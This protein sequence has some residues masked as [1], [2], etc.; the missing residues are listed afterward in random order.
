M[1]CKAHHAAKAIFPARRTIGTKISHGTG[2]VLLRE[3]QGERHTVTVV[4]NGYVWRE[5]TY[6]SL[7]IIARIN[8]CLVQSFYAMVVRLS[9]ARG[10]DADQPR[11]LQKITRTR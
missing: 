7:S 8:G 11:H 4:A 1:K 5:A 2:T 6:A 10:T 9:A 3:Y